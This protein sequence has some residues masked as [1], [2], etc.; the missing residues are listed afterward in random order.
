MLTLKKKNHLLWL[1]SLVELQAKE[2]H[3]VMES[4]RQCKMTEIAVSS[5]C[6]S[7]DNINLERNSLSPPPPTS[8][9]L[10]SFEGIVFTAR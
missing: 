6:N 7:K 1:S 10:L 3:V 8:A 2:N 9:L 5:S 4:I